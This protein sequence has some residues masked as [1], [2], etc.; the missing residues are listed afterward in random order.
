MSFR[1]ADARSQMLSEIAEAIGSIALALSS[2]GE[3][4]EELDE[5]SGERLEEEL[6]G[7]TQSAYGRARRTYDAFAGRYGF[8][9]APSETAA[10]PGRPGDAR[11]A[12]E[13]S[14]EALAHADGVLGT[15][16]D[17]MLPVDVGDQELRAGLTAVRE[18]IA[19]LPE[20]THSLLR[21]LGR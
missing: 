6:F 1:E 3:A 15:L 5:Q 14:A 18:L 13:R 7:P 19:P 17:S 21:V 11:G 10:Q 16:Q 4:Y 8:P 2:L 12:L 20:R 9:S